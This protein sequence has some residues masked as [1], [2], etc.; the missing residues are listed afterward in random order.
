MIRRTIV[1]ILMN[2]TLLYSCQPV[3]E[4]LPS[5]NYELVKKAKY[6]LLVKA[7]KEIK[8]SANRIG[9]NKISFEVVKSLKGNIKDKEIFLYGSRDYEG[10]SIEQQF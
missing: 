4:W 1:F 10:S 3:I 9:F 2:I 7:K 8:N 6:I 5:S